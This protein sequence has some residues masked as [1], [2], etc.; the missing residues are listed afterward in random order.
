VLLAHAVISAVTQISLLTASPGAPGSGMVYVAAWGL[1]LA[2]PCVVGALLVLLA[3]RIATQIVPDTAPL[4]IAADPV[5][6][7][8]LGFAITGIF[9]LV[10]GLEDVASMVRAALTKPEWLAGTPL[11]SYVWGEQ[12]VAVVRVVV[13]IVAGAALIAGRDG[14]ATAWW[15][16]RGRADEQDT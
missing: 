14:L 5:D 6:L 9:I 4:A 15:R 7:T 12:R 11:L 16:L 1:N 2:G 3:D 8:R 10:S 13:E